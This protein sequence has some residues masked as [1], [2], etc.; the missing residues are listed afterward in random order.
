MRVD[1]RKLAASTVLAGAGRGRALFAKLVDA[2]AKEAPEATALV[3]DFQGVDVATAS[4]LREA[5]FN[6]KT[7]MRTA[8]SNY[9][10]VV[11]NANSSIEDELAVLTDARSDAIIVCKCDASGKV[12]NP[13]LFGD[14]DPKQASTFQLVLER[15]EVDAVTLMEEFGEAEQTRT[16]TAWNNRLAGLVARGILREIP[17]GR[18]KLYRPVC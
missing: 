6:L 11:A 18:S 12:R 5:V 2:T 7:Y 17:R 3:L 10:P 1:I 4:F 16:A 15:G 8:G 14:L 13:Q 9:Y